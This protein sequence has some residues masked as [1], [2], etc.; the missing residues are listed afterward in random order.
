MARF[1]ACEHCGELLMENGRNWIHADGFFTCLAAPGHYAEPI[2]APEDVT[3][4]T[5]AARKTG[6]SE[7]WRECADTVRVA[8]NL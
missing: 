2:P 1:T 4:L 5:E 7:G 6:Y 8:L 3:A